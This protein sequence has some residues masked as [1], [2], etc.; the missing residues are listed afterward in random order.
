MIAQ[1]PMFL[2]AR[3]PEI[4]AQWDRHACELCSLVAVTALFDL[5]ECH[6]SFPGDDPGSRNFTIRAGPIPNGGHAVVL[7][8]GTV[9]MNPPEDADPHLCAALIHNFLLLERPDA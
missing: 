8:S 3:S 9:V 4:R 6:R 5:Y 1:E 7:K 2:A